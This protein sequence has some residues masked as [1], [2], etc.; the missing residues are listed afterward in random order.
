MTH[1][2]VHGQHCTCHSC[3]PA[4]LGRLAE[5]VVEDPEQRSGSL[6]ETCRRSPDQRDRLRAEPATV[7]GAADGRR[8]GWRAGALAGAAA[9]VA[10]V[11]LA[12]PAA[13][14]AQLSF[15][16][17]TDIFTGSSFRS[18]PTDI[19]VGDFNGDSDPDL[20]VV[21]GGDASVSVLLGKGDGTFANATNLAVGVG[22]RSVA[23]GD[24][25]GDSDLDLAVANFSGNNVSVLLGKGD[26]TFA[27]ATNVSVGGVSN[28]GATSV[29]V[30]HFN[31]DSDPDLAVT[32]G[33][34]GSQNGTVEVLLGGDGGSFGQQTGF[35]V[36]AYPV[37]VAVGHF[38]GD[39]DP[40]LAVANNG[41]GNVSV[42][43]GQQEA[44]GVPVSFGA[45]TN[46]ATG[47]VPWSVAVGDFDR[48][49]NDDLVVS[50]NGSWTISVLLGGGEGAFAAATNF[51]AGV[52]PG[53]VAVG[54]FNDDS[55]P[56]LAVTKGS[57]GASVMLGQAGG[58]FGAATDFL[59]GD[60]SW[61]IAAGDLDRDSDPDMAVT[62]PS[63]GY[64]SVVL[65]TT[66]R[67]PATADDAYATDEDTPLN[68]DA[69][70]VLENDSDP[71]GDTQSSS[72]VSGPGHGSL[73]LDDDGS[74]EYTPNGDYN[75]SDSFSYLA[76]DG[77]RDSAPATVTIE[78]RAVNDAPRATADSYA[79]EEDTALN[80][81]A[82]GV[83][84]NDSDFD[85]PV[86]N[87][88]DGS[89]PAHGTLR[90]EVDG[91]VTYTPDP[92][93][94]GTDSFSYKAWDGLAESEPATVTIE[95]RPVNDAG[96]TASGDSYATDEDAPL[97]IAAPGV[98]E[99]DTDF[100]RDALSATV[101]SEP[102]HGSLTLNAD[103][104]LTYTPEPDYNG[105]D[106]FTYRAS[107]GSLDSEPVTVTI[108]V[109]AV[110]DPS[111]PPAVPPPSPTP[112]PSPAP[113]G[114]AP[115]KPALAQ[116]RLGSR[117]VRGSRRGRVRIAM[118][119]RMANPAP[120]QVR[121]DR[122]VGTQALRSCPDAS[123][124]TG[125]YRKVA[126]LRRLSTRPAEAGLRRL[127]LRLRLAPGLYR[128]SVRAQLEGN[129]LSRP[130]R[131]YLWV[132]G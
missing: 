27:N 128:I 54:D 49:S 1:A 75:G 100:D 74:F 25:D 32:R 13:A 10:V 77:Q 56:D 57:S 118:T 16:G 131:R 23:V 103:G 111:P 122:R 20:A 121:I 90:L 14:P 124:F 34:I 84:G 19:A 41:S 66:N 58:S 117:C 113:G 35:A 59:T 2:T 92:D 71:D 53:K 43:L 125:R 24:F 76:S 94:Y 115:A 44:E 18:S 4:P 87:A 102:G 29:A 48:D 22:P 132:L 37:S 69:P 65:N 130:L 79:T 106:S 60:S 73:A 101:E 28:P 61:G 68:V 30:G 9:A 12:L 105:P 64:I 33:T 6:D 62:R 114:A 110:D 11:A 93:F 7:G 21:N 126:T 46:H 42:L 26:G 51:S 15:S 88:R 45:A 95:V 3:A 119:L 96:P 85:S 98:L 72:V 129:R 39:S 38:N 52:R 97:N 83:L 109:R 5:R 108:A 91:R 80:I 82:P 127:T 40:D 8:R 116:L 123:R 31:G 81:A 99:N 104:S 17:P 63:F 86:L 47:E 120:V 36:G 112:G 55:D 107:D 78:V 89:G 67:R 70:G 50:N